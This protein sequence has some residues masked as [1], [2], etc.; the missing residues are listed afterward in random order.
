[1]KLDLSNRSTTD[2]VVLMLTALVVLVLSILMLGAIAARFVYPHVE[3]KEAAELT[4][5]TIS[6]IV[7]ALVGFIGGR[8]VGKLEAKHEANNQNERKPE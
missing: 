1:M 6:T 8:S 3:M 5:N 4:I 2:L 7:G